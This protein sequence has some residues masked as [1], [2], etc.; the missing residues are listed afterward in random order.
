MTT[1]ALAM[2]RFL[3]KLRRIFF[4]SPA[5]TLVT[6]FTILA[7]IAFLEYSVP[8]TVDVALLY[9]VP[10]FLMTWYHSRGAGTLVSLAG[11]AV[12]L[13]DERIFS[14]DF[15]TH[16]QVYL[17]NAAIRLAT[18]LLFVLLL[19]KIKTLLAREKRASAL[20]SQF[21]HVVSHEFNNA[22]MSTYASLHL[23]RETEPE[24][25][26]GS[27][28]RYYEM[29]EAT[30]QKLKLYVKNILNEA[31]MEGGRFKLEKTDIALR[32][33]V[34]E[35]A[36]C[37]SDLAKLR[38]LTLVREYP[39]SAVFAS[40]DKEALALVISN[41]LGNAVK[42]TPPSGRITLRVARSGG[43]ADMVK[44]EVEDT[45]PGIS[46][47]DV[48]RIASGTYRKVDSRTKVESFGLGL[49]I[50]SELLALH[51]A[52]LAIASEKGKGSRFSFDLPVVPNTVK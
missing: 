8:N 35:A 30:N 29:L 43:S 21:M 3:V 37:M 50:S 16:P 18:F 41:L 49:R 33:V 19:S 4:G 23:L 27:R 42:Y 11:T 22:L 15:A 47:E 12:W 39:S 52:R 26:N 20:K 31:R 24:P 13:T 38:G 6:G 51:G 7:L 2:N 25:A 32:D 9:S 46:A 48:G 10:I 14:P 45:G 1:P 34:E 28:L 36:A 5:V 40:V 17:W 44:V